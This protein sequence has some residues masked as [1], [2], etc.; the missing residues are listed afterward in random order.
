MSCLALEKGILIFYVVYSMHDHHHTH[1]YR[2]VIKNHYIKGGKI[3]LTHFHYYK[4]R[5]LLKNGR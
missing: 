4:P 5:L 3:I 2:N 1:R